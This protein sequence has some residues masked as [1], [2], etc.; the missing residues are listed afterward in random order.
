[1][2][3]ETT[4][5]IWGKEMWKKLIVCYKVIGE[6]QSHIKYIANKLYH[7]NVAS[8]TVRIVHTTSL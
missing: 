1:M 6:H 5:C 4:R 8:T 2:I 3:A 7:K